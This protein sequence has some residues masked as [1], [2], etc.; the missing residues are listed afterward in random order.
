MNAPQSSPEVA[1]ILFCQGK[2]LVP[3]RVCVSPPN[4]EIVWC[5]DVVELC[6]RGRRLRSVCVVLDASELRDPSE[7]AAMVRSAVGPDTFVVIL[8]AP[9]DTAHV[10]RAIAIE[11][12]WS[13]EMVHVLRFT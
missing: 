7:A 3:D 10:D 5:R 12:G 11:D 4:A 6:E 2:H 13:A 8:G 9:A 1:Y